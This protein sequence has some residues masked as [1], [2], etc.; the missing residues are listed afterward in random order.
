[1][2]VYWLTVMLTPN[3]SVIVNSEAI[4][5]TSMYYPHPHIAVRGR[6]VA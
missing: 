2:P 5:F 1:M 3:S 6:A 4:V